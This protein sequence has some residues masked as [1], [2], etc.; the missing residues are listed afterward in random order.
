MGWMHQKRQNL[1]RQSQTTAEL[2]PND[3]KQTI[4][5]P[6]V[7]IEDTSDP[8]SYQHMPVETPDNEL[9]FIDSSIISASKLKGL[10]WIVI[11]NVV[12]D[13]TQ[14]APE[15]PGG[16]DFIESFQASDCSWQFW[17]FHSKDD[18]LRYGKALRIGMTK[19]VQ[20][21]YKERP[22]FIGL[23]GFWGQD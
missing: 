16:A 2:H 15:H 8:S 9:P 17:R 13:C 4:V 7:F 6:T 23:R 18:M 10:L 11:D 20:N 5:P 22:R 1:D 14:F 12:Y 19:G 21:K 3:T